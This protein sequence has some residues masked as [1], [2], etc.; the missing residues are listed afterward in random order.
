MD[1]ILTT[2]LKIFE[3][4]YLCI[5]CLGRM[6]SLLGSRTTNQDRGTSLL[7]SLT[8]EN[9]KNLLSNDD[10]QK[11]HALYN[12]K[13]LAE[14]ANYTPAQE[15][16]KIE[17]IGFSLINPN[18]LC[19][20]CQEIFSKIQKIGEKGI[21]IL[22]NIEFD[23]FLVGSSPD[24]QI[25][26]REDDLK[27][28]FGI[29]E[30]ESFKTHFNRE[31]GKFL[32]LHLKKPP[33][34]DT[35]DVSLIYHLNYESFYIELKIKSLFIRGRYNKFVRGIPQT[36]WSCRNCKGKGCE[37]CNYSGKQ[38]LTSVEELISPEFIAESR[39][40]ESK[41]H[42][43]GRED[44][45][46][47]MLGKGRPFILQ[48]KNPLIRSLDLVKLEKRVNK[49][50]K[51]KVKIQDLKYSSKREVINMKSEASKT[52]KVYRALIE[53]EK[54]VTKAFYAEKLRELKLT[55]ENKEINQ[56]TPQRVSH[57]R[58][59]KIRK[60][61]IHRIRGQF[62]NSTLFEFII[63]SQGG[64]YIKELING[65]Y[66][67]TSPSFSDVFGFSLICKELDVLEIN[68]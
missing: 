16:L 38:Y 65:D 22:K 57:R 44:I 2:V 27:S 20:L 46:V 5:H 15:V 30:A 25:I 55:F 56:R 49:I 39:S 11:E 48:L 10:D 7:L 40:T 17:G 21:E 54:R 8:M 62:I 51:K 59:D 66:G 28:E 26:N 50:N 34:F 42:G 33:E 3:K 6:F 63:E 4:H 67:R 24:P 14:R 52:L 31:M 58:A 43:A 23:N 64:T 18:Q 19:Y 1:M 47:K 36:H 53:T 61:K 60:K 41:F 45:D 37:S 68:Y 32:S 29:L 13:I 35:P 12:L 9:H